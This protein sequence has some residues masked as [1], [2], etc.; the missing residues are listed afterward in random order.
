MKIIAKSGNPK[1]PSL[2][3]RWGRRPAMTSKALISHCNWIGS[4]LA[5]VQESAEDVLWIECRTAKV[6]YVEWRGAEAL[7]LVVN[8]WKW[9]LST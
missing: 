3:S 8:P 4:A 2:E 1:R 6:A 9:P 5:S 7:L